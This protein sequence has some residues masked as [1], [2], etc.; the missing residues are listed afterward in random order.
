M[1]RTAEH[2]SALAGFFAWSGRAMLGAPTRGEGLLSTPTLNI[3]QCRLGVT[4][5]SGEETK[6]TLAFNRN[7]ITL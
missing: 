7:R 5:F 1:N 4:L 2:R 6:L 3:E